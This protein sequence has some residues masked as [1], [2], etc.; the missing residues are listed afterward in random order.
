VDCGTIS[1]VVLEL[2][3][4]RAALESLR[5]IS[6]RSALI[7]VRVLSV[8]M[9]VSRLSALPIVLSAVL[10]TVPRVAV[11]GSRTLDMLSVPI[12]RPI[13]EVDLS[14]GERR[15]VA[16]CFSVV[17]T[18]GSFLPMKLPIP[19]LRSV[20]SDERLLFTFGVVERLLELTAGC[21]ALLAADELR[22][23]IVLPIRERWL[24]VDSF[25]VFER[26][27]VLRLLESPIREAPLE[28][29]AG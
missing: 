22:V 7:S 9:R 20:R 24:V 19:R 27:G 25:F 8:L 11:F 16:D 28:R 26:D 10:P 6:L 5:L 13:R 23:P 14:S 21:F 17:E 18:E 12:V 29:A 1:L 4:N 3:L 2:S 15:L